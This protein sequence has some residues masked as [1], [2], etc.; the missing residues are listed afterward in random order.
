MDLFDEFLNSKL[1]QRK[2]QGLIRELNTNRAPVDFF[3]NDYLGLARS[4]DLSDAIEGLHRNLG[5]QNGS[6]G[7]RLLGGNSPFIEKV[8]YEL[9]RIFKSE[10]TLILNSGYA[11]NLSVL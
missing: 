8:E 11:A 2:E 4:K 10:A 9:S 5:V 1:A 3:S 7:S 6:T